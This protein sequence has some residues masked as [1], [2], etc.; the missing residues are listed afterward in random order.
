MKKPLRIAV[1]A[2]IAQIGALSATTAIAGGTS[3]T[4][5]GASGLGNSYA[6]LSS[7]AEDASVFYWNPAA[8]TRFKK[9]ELVGGLLVAQLETQYTNSN[10]PPCEDANFTFNDKASQQ[11]A[12]RGTGGQS[13]GCT[14]SGVPGKVSQRAKPARVAIPFNFAAIPMSDKLVLGFGVSGSSGLIVRFPSDSPG[15]TQAE[16]TDL[17]VVRLTA[18]A[19]YKLTPTLSVGGSF[20]YERMFTSIR[21]R[22]NFDAAVSRALQQM[23]LTAA[24]A[25]AAANAVISDS[26]AE[27]SL[28]ISVYGWAVNGQ[29][30]ALWEPS[31]RTR[32]GFGF[33]PKTTFENQGQLVIN[34]IPAQLEANPQLAGEQAVLLKNFQE[35]RQK[36]TL[37]SELNVSVF[38][39]LTPKLDVMASYLRE[40]FTSTVVDFR[41]LDGTVIQ[42]PRQQFQVTQ[43]Y[44]LGANYKVAKRLMLRGGFAT[45]NGAVKDDNR[46]QSLPDNDRTFF[47]LGARLLWDRGTYVD[48]GYQKIRFKDAVVGLNPQPTDVVYNGINKLDVDIL[49]IQ[50][51]DQF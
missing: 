26:E 25:R 47:N 31:E 35:V 17:K 4:E 1:A 39:S 30:G 43:R 15:R 12:S 38:H 48:V 8:V 45:E 24:A 32:V 27:T 10:T 16:S 6:G 20:G 19:G 29:V 50:L 28:R 22:L 36:I 18:G 44:A 51:V 34:G 42:N 13:A 41:A 49:G 46:L 9:A 23:G 33:R 7:A 14:P 37:P 21:A 3:F 40:D 11:A 5:Q 2:A